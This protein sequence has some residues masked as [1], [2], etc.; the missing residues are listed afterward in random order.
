MN[1]ATSEQQERSFNPIQQVIADILNNPSLIKRYSLESG[2]YFVLA[3]KYDK[4]SIFEELYKPIAGR[5]G[6]SQRL[7]WS[8]VNKLIPSINI[9]NRKQYTTTFLE[10]SY[11]NTLSESS[12]PKVRAVIFPDIHTARNEFRTNMRMP[13]YK[14]DNE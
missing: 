6:K 9:K 7:F 13:L 4:K 3:G 1:E 14:F 10:N 12:R 5:Y 2:D 8:D 11:F